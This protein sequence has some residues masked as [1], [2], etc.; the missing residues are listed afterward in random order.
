MEY[1]VL[2]ILVGVISGVVLLERRRGADRRTEDKGMQTQTTAPPLTHPIYSGGYVTSLSGPIPGSVPIPSGALKHNGTFYLPA[3]KNTM[4]KIGILSS[5]TQTNTLLN[6]YVH[7][8]LPSQDIWEYYVEDKD[9]FIIKLDTTKEIRDGD[10][11]NAVPGKQGLGPWKVYIFA[12][13]S[14]VWV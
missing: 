2:G 14:Y 9:G 7:P 12:T 1:A 5:T 10:I 8:V 4:S 6:L 11:I 13:S 3:G